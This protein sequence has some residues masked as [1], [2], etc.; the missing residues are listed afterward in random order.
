MGASQ[1]LSVSDPPGRVSAAD[2]GSIRW[3]RIAVTA[4][5]VVA[6]TL[7]SRA[8]RERQPRPHAGQVAAL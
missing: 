7:S 2:G 5:F 1:R 3:P 8:L 4:A 6:G